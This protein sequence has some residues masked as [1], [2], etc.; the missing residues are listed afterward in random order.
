VSVDAVTIDLAGKTI[1]AGHFGGYVP[2]DKDTGDK[3]QGALG[4]GVDVFV[5]KLKD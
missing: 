5:A 4:D 2:F 3:G 1:V